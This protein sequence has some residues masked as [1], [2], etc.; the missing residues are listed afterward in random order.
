MSFRGTDATLKHL[1]GM[2]DLAVL[3][4][5][6]GSEVHVLDLAGAPAGANRGLRADVPAGSAGDAGEV[7]DA[8]ARDA[9]RRRLEELED[10]LAEAEQ[11]SD[12]A[13]VDRARIEKE[14]LVAELAAAYGLSGRVRRAGDPAE[15]ARTTVTWR[16][17]EAIKRIEEAHPDL[18]RHLRASVRTGTFCSYSPEQPQAWRF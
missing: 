11:A 6:P 12:G 9:Y 3:L 16:I 13:A 15:R 8:R 17:R 18:G 2:A 4:A 5:R 14:F 10:D 7:L 1:K